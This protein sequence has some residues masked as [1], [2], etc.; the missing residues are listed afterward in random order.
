MPVVCD[1]KTMGTRNSNIRL[2]KEGEKAY[3]ERK[4]SPC[5]HLFRFVGWWF[6]FTG[7]YAMFAV[8]PFCEQ[9]GCPVGL[10]SAGTGIPLGF[11]PGG[12]G[13]TRRF[14]NVK[15]EA[16]KASEATP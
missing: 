2:S 7:L 9:Q 16:T 4:V 3:A 6:G 1:V 10:A 14:E 5:G 8:C 13:G 12:A 11:I 15:E